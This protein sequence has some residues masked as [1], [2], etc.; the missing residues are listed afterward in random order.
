MAKDLPYFKFYVSEW[1][2]GDITLEDYETQGL[3]VNICSYY[4]SN[5]CNVSIEKLNKKFRN[6][7]ENIKTL[8]D[9]GIIKVDEA[10]AVVISFLIEQ[11]DERGK[12]SSTNSVN[13]KL[14]WERKRL[15]EQEES[16]RNATASKPQCETYAIK[17]RGEEKR[18]EEKKDIKGGKPNV[19][20]FKIALTELGVEKD[21]VSD[22][23][24]VRAKKKLSN[25]KT[26]FT[27]ISNEIKKASIPANKCIT[28]AVEKSWGGFEADWLSVDD[29]K[30]ASKLDSDGQKKFKVLYNDNGIPLIHTEEE[31][32]KRCERLRL[33]V[34]QK[35][36]YHGN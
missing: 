32:K 36:A 7:T 26:A 4:W 10:G 23:L 18:E 14:R 16:E 33:K 22:W 12:L 11:L 30:K 15:A 1:T 31:I 27:R 35:T 29:I 19:F 28:I 21:I 6:N 2:D 34:V 5:D 17:R 3:F 8:L 25:T 13:A 24:R 20:D 9:V